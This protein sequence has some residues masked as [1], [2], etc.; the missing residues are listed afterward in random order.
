MV[1]VGSGLTVTDKGGKS[2]FTLIGQDMGGAIHLGEDVRF[3][4]IMG[5]SCVYCDKPYKRWG[6]LSR[7]LKAKH[8]E[9]Y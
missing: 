6:W 9:H 8:P 4:V 2:L 5:K 3:M 1:R 7:H